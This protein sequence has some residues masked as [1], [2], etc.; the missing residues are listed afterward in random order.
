[1]GANAHTIK[2]CVQSAEPK[3]LPHFHILKQNM[4]NRDNI[5]LTSFES[6]LR[7]REFKKAKP[8]EGSHGPTT[9]RAFYKIIAP[10]HLGNAGPIHFA[11]MFGPLL[12]ENGVPQ[13]VSL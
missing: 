6:K 4:V 13:Y 12:I 3:V 7:N 2:R 1:M 10:S 8:G 9:K 11:L 5:G